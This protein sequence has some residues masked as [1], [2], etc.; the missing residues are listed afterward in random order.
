MSFV[1]TVPQLGP[2]LRRGGAIS[3]RAAGT[4]STNGIVQAASLAPPR[5]RPGSRWGGRCDG[6]LSFV[7]TVPQLGPGLRR[8]GAISL[9]AA[10]TISTN[11]IVQAASLAPPRRRPG[12]RW[13]GRC[14]DVLSCVT[15]APQL[16]PGL[17][18]GGCGVAG[19]RYC[20]ARRAVSPRRRGSSLGSRLRG[21]TGRRRLWGGGR[22][23]PWSRVADAQR[24]LHSGGG[25][26]QGI[27]RSILPA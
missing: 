20:N 8:G 5:R 3:L 11:G 21:R 19:R 27:I 24:A 14:D 13:G 4:I 16:G 22:A 6:A 9:R 17:R 2:G 26:T 18:R 1:T 25:V 15:V 10:G 7:T 12:S 23:I